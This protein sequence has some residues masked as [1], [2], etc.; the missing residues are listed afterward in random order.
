MTEVL[1]AVLVVTSLRV[2]DDPNMAPSDAAATQVYSRAMALFEPIFRA[3]DTAGVRY[4]T[5]G[6]VAVVLHGYARLTADLDLAVDLAAEPA[7]AAI[8]ALTSIG[9]HPRAPVDA[10]D[11]ADAS[12]RRRWSEQQGMT[13]FSMWDPNDPL[14]SVDLFVANPI[15]FEDLWTRSEVVDL[16]GTPA[17]IAS[18]PDLIRL[19]KIAA[20]PLDLDDIQ[21][22][23]Q[24]LA[25]RPEGR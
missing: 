21:A 13:V 8:E 18:I 22:L 24:I 23:E 6:G 15:D 1:V 17:R 19:K 20:R 25:A 5:V 16:A 10:R 12:A 7:A 4:V 2:R 14:R 3:L 9:L 11:F